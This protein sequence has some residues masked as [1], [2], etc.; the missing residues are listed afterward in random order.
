MTA[1]VTAE[2]VSALARAA[3]AENSKKCADLA[4]IYEK[5]ARLRRLHMQVELASAQAE[6]DKCAAPL[7]FFFFF[8]FFFCGGVWSKRTKKKKNQCERAESIE[9]TAVWFAWNLICRGNGFEYVRIGALLLLLF[10]DRE[11]W[12]Q[13]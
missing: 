4:A 13:V 7:F 1:A 9:T 2:Q 11:F 5:N 6:A 8:F 3:A 10:F 12:A